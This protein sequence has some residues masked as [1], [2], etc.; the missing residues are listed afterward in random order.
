V[1]LTS[2]LERLH[3]TR[4]CLALT[5]GSTWR[6]GPSDDDEEVAVSSVLEDDRVGVPPTIPE[7]DEVGGV[8]H[9]NHPRAS[10]FCVV[11]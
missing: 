11:E 9:L 5:D 8:G 7:D 3:P 4:A 6:C 2:L 1:D 10:R